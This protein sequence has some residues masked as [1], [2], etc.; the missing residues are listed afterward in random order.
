[1]L[2][3]KRLWVHYR[4][5]ARHMPWRDNPQ[6][7]WVLVSE[8]ML[9][10]TQV[11]RVLPKFLDFMERFP[12]LAELAAAPLGEVLRAWS[13][14]GY[15]RRAKFL[16]QAAQRVMAEFGGTIPETLA[17]LVGLPGVGK[18][19]AGALLAYAYNQPVVFVETNIR[20]VYFHHFFAGTGQVDDAA[21]REL[22]QQT[23]DC[24]HPRE[25][26]WALM[27][28]GA[29]LK[30]SGQGNIAQS[31]HYTKQ[32][33]FAG[34]RRQIRGRILKLLLEKPMVEAELKRAVADE[35]CLPVLKELQAEGLVRKLPD[36]LL[37]A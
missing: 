7:Y 32:S 36:G 1:L 6:P 12:T 29:Y 35:R 13:G 9:Q 27:D 15:N 2:I 37:V 24:E 21:V 3:F 31:H 30:Q 5:A 10:Q 8:L 23:I 20:S 22:V 28:Y 16:H 17:E 34:S 26:Y 4:Q 14:L 25:W 33:T 18:N 11:S 19:T